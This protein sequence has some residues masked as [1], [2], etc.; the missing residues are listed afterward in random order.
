LLRVMPFLKSIGLES[1]SVGKLRVIV[2]ECPRIVD[3]RALWWTQDEGNEH[4]LYSGSGTEKGLF[5][6]KDN[7][8]SQDKFGEGQ[9]RKNVRRCI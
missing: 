8:E 2:F 5:W 6:D 3:H 4:E 7:G 9:R 1:N